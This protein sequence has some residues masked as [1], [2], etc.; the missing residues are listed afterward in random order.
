MAGAV[1]EDFIRQFW[2]DPEN[3]ASFSGVETYR[4]ELLTRGINVSTKKLIQILSKIPSY[5]Q[6]SSRIKHF[7]RRSYTTHGWLDCLEAD[8]ATMENF[9]GHFL[10]VI[11]VYTLF[12]WTTFLSTKDGAKII[13]A[14]KHIFNTFGI[15]NLVQHD[16][17]TE[18]RKLDTYLEE[19]KIRFK[20]RRGPIK[21]AY[22]ELGIKS[23]K[24]Q[25]FMF[26]RHNNSE[27][28]PNML[29]IVTRNWNH[30]EH[31]SIGNLRPI[32]LTSREKA[33]EID[34]RRGYK[35]EPDYSEMAKNQQDFI[36]KSDLHVGDYAYIPY[37]PTK[38]YKSTRGIKGHDIQVRF[39]FSNFQTGFQC[40][41][42]SLKLSKPV[43]KF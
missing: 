9:S 27:D 23:L 22:A 26:M 24:K 12:I 14:F 43:P 36:K 18:F 19:K 41:K 16:L 8:I 13:A 28:W 3:P 30:R 37:A 35:A 7:P 29:D 1:N 6:N 25:L 39:S 11:D 40:A 15:P 32:N 42:R 21:C 2:Q 5:L 31:K 10:L 20:T 17:G 38:G 4:K 34:L 33:V